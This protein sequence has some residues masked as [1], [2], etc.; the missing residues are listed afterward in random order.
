V[1]PAALRQYGRL[2]T[3]VDGRGSVVY[4][5]TDNGGGHDAILAV[6]PARR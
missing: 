3:V 6:R 5:P 1:A 4:V 2:R